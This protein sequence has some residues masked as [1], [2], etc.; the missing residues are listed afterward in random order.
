MTITEAKTQQLEG[1]EVLTLTRILGAPP[2]RVFAAFT[3]PERLKQ[4][5]GPEGV[6]TPV[7]EIDP[8]PGGAYHFEMQMQGGNAHKLSGIFR[9]VTPPKRLVYTFVWEHGDFAGIEMLVTI[10]LRPH[11]DGTELVLTQEGIPTP[12]SRDSHA[13]GWGGSLDKLKRLVE[14][15]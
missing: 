11:G 2:E 12:S 5:W 4:W 15:V 7:A 13:H 10:E 14:G 6:N 9:E 8:R 3:E 1:G